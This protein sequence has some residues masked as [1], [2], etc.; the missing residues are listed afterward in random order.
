TLARAIKTLGGNAAR[1]SEGLSFLRQAESERSLPGLQL[2]ARVDKL[3]RQWTARALV[4]LLERVRDIA[5]SSTAA[6]RVAV[7]DPP[8]P[9]QAPRFRS[10]MRM[11]PSGS[12]PVLVQAYAEAMGRVLDTSGL[13]FEAV[14]RGFEFGARTQAMLTRGGEPAML[15]MAM[16][17]H[18]RVRAGY[19]GVSPE[20]IDAFS[21]HTFW[22]NHVESSAAKHPK[23]ER[24]FS[25][26][27]LRPYAL[28]EP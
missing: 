17:S 12:D 9:A 5:F 15:M 24:A 26:A 28:G 25:G 18:A 11:L 8:P 16:V 4:P 3:K 22:L 2:G 1:F 13:P 20:E 10:A 6:D 27:V 7:S 14:E 19:E 23:D 21:S